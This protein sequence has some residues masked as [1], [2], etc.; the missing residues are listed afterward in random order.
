MGDMKLN[1]RALIV[2]GAIL[3]ALVLVGLVYS[4]IGAAEEHPLPAALREPS[5]APAFHGVK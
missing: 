3:M 4:R 2:I 1:A 5:G